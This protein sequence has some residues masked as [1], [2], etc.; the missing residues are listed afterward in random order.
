MRREAD[1]EDKRD[2]KEEK[3]LNYGFY[4][5]QSKALPKYHHA[6]THS[7]FSLL[8]QGVRTTSFTLGLSLLLSPKASWHLEDA[9]LLVQRGEVLPTS[10]VKG[11][12]RG[13][14]GK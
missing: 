12:Q 5:L 13:Q 14:N 11:G 8:T 7:N 2:R 6:R 10:S 9:A 4:P 1:G 3:D